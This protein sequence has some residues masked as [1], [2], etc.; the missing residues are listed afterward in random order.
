M[1]LDEAGVRAIAGACAKRGYQ[2]VAV[3]FLFS[4]QNAAHEQR[5]RE[6]LREELPGVYLSLSAEVAPV[7]GEYERS[8]TALFN[9]YVGPVIEQYLRRL[10]ERAG[11][12]RA[13]AEAAD[14][15][16]QRRRRRPRRRRC[17]SSRSSPGL[18]PAS[19]APRRSPSC[20]GSP[21]V[22]ATDVG[23]TTFKVAIVQDGEL[24]LQPRDRR[25]TST[26]CAC[27]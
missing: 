22:I 20:S 24:G 16:G 17:P 26:S 7:I 21:N 5:A 11:R 13:E 6:I 27:R 19:S 2:A 18:R 14:R 12:G 3:A 8:A 23:G 9:A 15:A 1:P 4:H 10:E 25:S